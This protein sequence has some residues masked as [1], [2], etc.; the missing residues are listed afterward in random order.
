MSQTAWPTSIT[1]SGKKV[2]KH[3]TNYDCKANVGT[4]DKNFSMEL[5]NVKF[6][7]VGS[8]YTELDLTQP[9]YVYPSE[10]NAPDLDF[11]VFLNDGFEG[12]PVA[13]GADL[14]IGQ[15]DGEEGFVI[16]VDDSS[17]ER[18]LEWAIDHGGVPNYEV[19][20]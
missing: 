9:L 16:K 10:N 3:F 13:T 14:C 12:V 5:K 11:F 20:R 19:A 8:N 7:G 17:I 4:R 2:A 15:I 6:V 18:L 1:F